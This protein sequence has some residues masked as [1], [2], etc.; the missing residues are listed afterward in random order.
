[1]IVFDVAIKVLD[2][3]KFAQHTIADLNSGI[4]LFCLVTRSL[5]SESKE[6]HT[7]TYTHA[8]AVVG[9]KRISSC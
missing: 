5:Y 8:L 7:H 3:E 6:T 1:M 4:A 2:T 9:P